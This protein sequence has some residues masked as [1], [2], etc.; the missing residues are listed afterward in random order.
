MNKYAQ[1][2]INIY[3]NTLRK[4]AA[5]SPASIAF[6]QANKKRNDAFNKQVMDQ[7]Q[8]SAIARAKGEAATLKA[9][10]RVAPPLT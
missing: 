1:L 6:E 9:N 4:L 8:M 5:P 10:S 2:Y 3:D 7:R